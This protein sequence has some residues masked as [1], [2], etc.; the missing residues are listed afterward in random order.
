[1]HASVPLLGERGPVG[2][3]NLADAGDAPFDE[4]TLTLLATVGKQL[5]AAFE[6]SR[7]QRQRTAQERYAATLEER[8]RLA[9]EM[10]DVL[11]QQLFAAQLSLEVARGRRRSGPVGVQAEDA[12]TSDALDQAA[13]SLEAAIA[14]LRSLVEVLRPAE[15][16]GGLRA[17]LVRLAHRTAPSLTVHL[18]IEAPDPED[19]EIAEL[20]YKAAQE[21]V[22]NALRHARAQTAWVRMRRKGGRLEL[23]VADD[24]V[25]FPGA[26]ERSV[27]AGL[28]LS[29]TRERARALGGELHVGAR[30]GGGA[31]VF[32]ELPWPPAS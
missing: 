22:H 9:R 14:E 28:G 5:A 15:L 10:H 21:A 16:G 3:L 25:G 32:V 24:G 1:M 31:D 8:G 23:G 12:V 19:A 29:G 7:L 27:G 4:E 30:P 17:A 6:R 11:A 26:P 20:L 18:D 2:I 13:S